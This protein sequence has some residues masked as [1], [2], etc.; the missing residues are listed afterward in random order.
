MIFEKMK[1]LIETSG[2]K[3]DFTHAL[4]AAAAAAAAAAVAAA[5]A[6]ASSDDV[7]RWKY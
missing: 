5:A 2:L 6:A 7:I 4:A 1:V 3:N